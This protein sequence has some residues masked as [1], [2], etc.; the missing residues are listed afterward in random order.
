VP[1]FKKGVFT[2]RGATILGAD[3]KSGVAEILELLTTIKDGFVNE[4]SIEI[5]FTVDEE[6]GATG[7]R[8]VRP[9]WLKGREML[10]LDAGESGKITTAAP[11]IFEYEVELTG[12]A[13]HS[14][15]EPEKGRNALLVA[16]RAIADIP[17]GRIDDRSTANVGF[18]ASGQAINAVPA[19]ATFKGEIRS[20]ERSRADKIFAQTKAA[21]ESAA[22]P[23]GV[24]ASIHRELWCEGYCY[25]HTDP[26]IKKA[27]KLMKLVGIRPRLKVSGGASDAN[28]LVGKDFRPLDIGAGY[29]NPHMTTE[30]VKLKDMVRVVELLQRYVND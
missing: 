26:H 22:K 27:V 28:T 25:S 17:V 4:R 29:K 7:A 21:V 16:A 30:T 19:S 15:A 11:F 9:E 8:A 6:R 13:A 18:L 14:G 2:S 5:L 20:H 23:L 12:R 24:R 10:I 3:D 1:V